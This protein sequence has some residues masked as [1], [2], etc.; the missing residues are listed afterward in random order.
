MFSGSHVN[1]A[2][3]TFG[4]TELA[5]RQPPVVFLIRNKLAGNLE[6]EVR[7]KAND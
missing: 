7:L 6:V 4:L 2:G 1:L 3:Q 5:L